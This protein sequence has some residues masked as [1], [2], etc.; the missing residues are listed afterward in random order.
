MTV[1]RGYRKFFRLVKYNRRQ[2]LHDITSSFNRTEPGR[3]SKHTVHGRLQQ[4]TVFHSVKLIGEAVF[5]GV[6]I[7]YTGNLHNSKKY[8]LRMTLNH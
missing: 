6:D 1:K 7:Q 4:K 3:F 8:N 2:S 5:Y